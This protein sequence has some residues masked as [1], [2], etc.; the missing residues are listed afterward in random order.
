VPSVTPQPTGD[1]T[2]ELN[3]QQVRGRN[4]YIANCGACHS[5]YGHNGLLP[6]L[7]RSAP[8]IIDALD[9]IVLQGALESRGMPSFAG[10]ITPAQLE[11]LKAYLR[12][13]RIE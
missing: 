13:I 10:D 3:E 2:R 7:R 1:R 5:W 11:D 6:D 4:L 8:T 9:V 12:A